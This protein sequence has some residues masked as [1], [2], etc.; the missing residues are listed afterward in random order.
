MK[1]EVFHK[2]KYTARLSRSGADMRAAQALRYRA[3]IDP[4]GVGLD[5]DRF[6]ALC[7]HVLIEDNAG[8]LVAAYRLQAFDSGA[9]I[10][11]S[12]AA[13]FYDLARLAAYGGRMLEMGRFCIRPGL[14]DPEILRTAWAMMTRIVDATGVE[15]MFGCSSF[16]GTDP[17]AHLAGFAMLRKRFLAPARWAPGRKAAHLFVFDDELGATASLRAVPPLLRTYLAM[18]GWVSDHA[19]VDHELG[20]LHVFTGLE[21]RAVPA[22]R[23]RALRAAAKTTPPP[24]IL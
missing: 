15:L 16:P 4:D 20:T 14:R 8:A 22:P 24:S 17:R 19:V 23:A 13:Q 5:Q 3:F 2:G 12:Y 6:D 9:Q 10:A 18:G 21:V 7:Q 1:E 11:R